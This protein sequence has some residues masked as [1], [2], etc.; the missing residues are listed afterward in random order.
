MRV[1]WEESMMLRGWTLARAGGLRRTGR[2]GLALAAVA[3]SGALAACS[4][5]NASDDDDAS[6]ESSNPW[7][8]A[9]DIAQVALTPSVAHGKRNVPVDTEVSVEAADGTIDEVVLSYNDEGRKREV[10]GTVSSEG[11]VWTADD[12]LEPGERYRLVMRGEGSDGQPLTERSRFRTENL[13][14]D[15]QT[16]MEYIQ[17]YDGETYGVGMP[18]VIQFDIPVTD[19]ASIERSLH[20]TSTPQ[21]QGTWHW[22]SDT[23]VHYR[24]KNYWPAGTKVHVDADINGVS[25][26]NGIYGQESEEFDFRIGRKVVSK[27]DLDKHR[28]KVFIDDQLANTIP[29]TG[30]MPGYET[31]SGTKV[32]MEKYET[33][34]MDAATTGV[35]ENDPEY[36]NI[37]NVPNALR[38]TWSGEFLHGAPWSEGSQG[39]ANVSHGCVGMSVENSEWMYANTRIGD[40]VQVTGSNR[41]IE[42]GNGWTDWDV[43]WEQYVRGS[44]LN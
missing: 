32:I 25:A 22:Y 40:V 41:S 28:M 35:S 5:S 16:Y 19:K 10:P 31:R 1:L 18:V 9:E 14:L 38:V 23:E 21:V 11:T 36:Y 3:A 20:V 12:L 4:E 13:T 8:I 37:A 30:G 6:G 24:P 17:P 2:I 34:D 44:A 39:F 42:P 26:G 7:D 15:E 43:P 27:I 29:V 33:K